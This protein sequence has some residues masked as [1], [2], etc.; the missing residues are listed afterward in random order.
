MARWVG[1]AGLRSRLPRRSAWRQ[2]AGLFPRALVYDR[3]C[4]ALRPRLR[5]A[6]HHVSIVGYNFLRRMR[7]SAVRNGQSMPVWAALR[8]SAHAVTCA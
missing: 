2:S 7:A 1:P 6:L 3:L 4:F 8:A 5:L